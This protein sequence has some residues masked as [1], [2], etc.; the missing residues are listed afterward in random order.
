MAGFL[1][2]LSEALIGGDAAEER[3]Y[4]TGQMQ[5]SELDTSMETAHLRREQRLREE[6]ERIMAQTKQGAQGRVA[7]YEG[8]YE[9]MP[10][11]DLIVGGY[12]SDYAGV[13]QG[14]LRGQEHRMREGIA[15]PSVA[16]ELR[17][18]Q[19]EAIEPSTALVS[20]REPAGSTRNPPSGYQW[21]ETGELD[22]IPGGPADKPASGGGFKAADTNA[23]YRQSSGLFGGTYN[24]L[25]GQFTG[26]DR[27]QAEQAQR[28]ASRASQIYAAGGVDHATAV[29]IALQEMRGPGGIP[30]P[31]FG[32]DLGVDDGSSPTTDEYEGTTATGPNGEKVVWRGGQ[33]VSL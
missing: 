19:M 4:Y 6:A 12:G 27:D 2:K 28:I 5:R 1:K 26:L 32:Q 10:I 14:R 21:T 33:W 3:G 20:R 15:D 30:A 7:G 29:D 13:G 16:E 23:I 22:V 25:T 24:P 31:S 8:G 18:A 11:S 9:D 17:I